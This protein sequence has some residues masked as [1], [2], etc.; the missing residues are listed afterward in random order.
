[1][2]SSKRSGIAMISSHSSET[3]QQRCPAWSIALTITSWAKASSFWTC[4]PWTFRSPV[5]PST[6]ISPAMFTSREMILAASAMS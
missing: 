1:M 6:S 4:S 2:P 3:M 5:R